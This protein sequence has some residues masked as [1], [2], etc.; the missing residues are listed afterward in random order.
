M[1]SDELR[2]LGIDELSDMEHLCFISSYV[3]NGKQF[4]ILVA[5]D[6]PVE[7]RKG[8]ALEMKYLEEVNELSFHD[9]TDDKV[10]YR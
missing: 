7:Y 2:I 4:D 1:A 5:D 9:G 8:E 3:Y 10:V 6:P